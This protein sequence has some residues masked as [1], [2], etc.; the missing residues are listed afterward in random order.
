MPD[1]PISQIEYAAPMKDKAARFHAVAEGR[2][3]IA[4]GRLLTPESIDD[5]IETIGTA[6]ERPLLQSVAI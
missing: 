5:W 2:A 6:Y 3:D 1:L 4:A